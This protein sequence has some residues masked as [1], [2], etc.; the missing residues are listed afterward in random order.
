MAYTPELNIK[1]SGTLRRIAWAYAIPMTRAIEGLFDYASKFID[2]KKVC[3]ACRDRSFCE[4]CPFNHNG[5][6]SQLS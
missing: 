6:N 1:Y 2:S 3:D 5:Q 4:Q